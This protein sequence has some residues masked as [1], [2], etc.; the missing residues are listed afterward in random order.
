MFLK[1]YMSFICVSV[2]GS[3]YTKK[4]ISILMKS[5]VSI[6]VKIKV[7]VYEKIVTEIGLWADV[8][9]K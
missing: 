8:T 1:L 2:S 3:C 7:K 4:M 6:N 5:L 9:K